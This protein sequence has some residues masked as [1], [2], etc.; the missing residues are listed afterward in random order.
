MASPTV[1]Y[2]TIT[3]VLKI[4]DYGDGK[5]DI[6]E[7]TS[8]EASIPGLH[9]ANR[10]QIEFPLPVPTMAVRPARMNGGIV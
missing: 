1:T 8:D 6:K 4:S 7:V 5:Y 2:S 3:T 9:S 10:K